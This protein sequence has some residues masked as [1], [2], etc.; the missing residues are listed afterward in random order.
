[1]DKYK[2][3]YELNSRAISKEQ[4]DT[5]VNTYLTAQSNMDVA[6]RQYDL[7]K[8]GAW[9]YDIINQEKQYEALQKAYASSL[10]L[11]E[12]YTLKAPKDGLVLSVN[13]SA[14]SYISP[15]GSYDT[16][17]EGMS[18][19]LVLSGPPD[20]YQVRCYVDEILLPRLPDL[21]DVVAQMSIRGSKH[22]MPLE[23]VRVQPYVSPKVE[24]SDQRTERVDVRV[25]PLIFRFQRPRDVNIYPGQLV[26][27]YIGGR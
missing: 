15:L 21:T 24:L 4:L 3:A 17:T 19:T 9:I 16:Y 25:L 13:T 2:A 6:Q 26:D 18:P 11:L 12:K 27:V 23:F 5:A 1:M 22:R 7:T 8:A 14:G 10:A 20:Y